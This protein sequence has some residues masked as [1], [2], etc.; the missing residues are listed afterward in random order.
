MA[1]PYATIIKVV[2]SAKNVLFVRRG[3]GA[4]TRP[5]SWEWPG[6]HVE[7]G[8]TAPE[9]AVRELREETGIKFREDELRRIGV[10]EK[11][12][13]LYVYYEAR[14]PKG[15]KVKLSFE[16]DSF[17]WRPDVVT[18][19]KWMS[20]YLSGKDTKG[21]STEQKIS[22]AKTEA[23]VTAGMLVGERVL[24]RQA[25]KIA[26]KTAA[27]QGVK[28]AG[29]SVPVAGWAVTGALMAYDAAPEAWAVGKEGV[30]LGKKSV[31]DI[32]K[33]K[34]FKGK[35]AAIKKGYVEGMKY[36]LTGLARVGTA[37]VVGSDAVK[38]GREALAEKRAKEAALKKNSAGSFIVRGGRQMMKRGGKKVAQ[39]V[40]GRSIT[41]MVALAGG[42][43]VTA[44]GLGKQ[45]AREYVETKDIL[46]GEKKNPA[47]YEAEIAAM[48]RDMPSD[49]RRQYNLG[50]R[51]LVA[52]GGPVLPDT[53]TPEQAARLIG[54]TA[55][56]N[57][58]GDS[59]TGSS[60]VPKAVRDEAM[61]GLRLSHENNYGAWSFIGIARAIQLATTSAVSD[62]TKS[63]MGRYFT[64]HTKD[65]IAGGFGNDDSPSRGYMAWLNWGGEAGRRWV[66]GDAL[67][68]PFQFQAP[69]F[70]HRLRLLGSTGYTIYREDGIE[71]KYAKAVNFS[72]EDAALRA[73]A[74]FLVLERADM[75]DAKDASQGGHKTA[76]SVVLADGRVYSARRSQNDAFTISGPGLSMPLSWGKWAEVGQYPQTGLFVK[77]NPYYPYPN[78]WE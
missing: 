71:K 19:P 12:K 42:T 9:A 8:E 64:R 49:W 18:N 45:A 51:A 30:A 43:L 16:H 78:W 13:G 55:G 77:S 48:L 66:S 24:V 75:R 31:A 34:G 2:D 50:R 17:E 73:L 25:G 60:R 21:M 7:K 44:M 1:R 47:G 36:Q 3:P 58:S 6:G 76:A 40:A 14:V 46:K 70:W 65:K 61:K 62:T 35:A 68:N 23:A 11:P 59:V 28:A 57:P 67:S 10:E 56:G 72:E 15:Q 52:A 69:P 54:I 39:K 63:R 29:A 38:M 74:V 37:S 53:P 20:K 4:P 22:E 33:A 26:A 41:G 27:K 5:G 32:K